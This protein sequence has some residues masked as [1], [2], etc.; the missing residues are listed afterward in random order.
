LPAVDGAAFK[1]RFEGL[2]GDARLE[3]DLE[4]EPSPDGLL[5]IVFD[6]DFPDR[7]DNLALG[8][9][10]VARGVCDC[11][12]IEFVVG[13]CALLG[14]L[15]NCCEAMRRREGDA[16]VGDCCEA[17]EAA[18]RS[19]PCEALRERLNLD[20]E[21]EIERRKV[22]TAAVTSMWL[23]CVGLGSVRVPPPLF[24]K[25]IVQGGMRKSWLLNNKELCCRQEH[26]VREDRTRVPSRL[27]DNLQ[28]S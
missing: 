27:G 14:L 16:G 12:R 23:W 25:D 24:P 13:A 22:R 11:D 10:G 21:R 17:E 20:G 8:R 6:A 3:I 26:T 4:A 1:A 18:E 15:K 2:L 28:R 19:E 5:R 9:K 7:R